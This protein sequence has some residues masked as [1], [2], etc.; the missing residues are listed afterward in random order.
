MRLDYVPQNP[1]Y[2]YGTC[3]ICFFGSSGSLVGFH[4]TYIT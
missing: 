2:V 4:V 3:A 1:E